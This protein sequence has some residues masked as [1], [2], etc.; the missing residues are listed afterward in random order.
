MTALKLTGVCKS[1]GPVEVLKDID[2]T[3]EEGEF[4]VFVGPSGCGKSTLLR[5][6]AGLEEITSGDVY[7]GGD[8]VKDRIGSIRLTQLGMLLV[9]GSVAAFLVVDDMHAAEFGR[10]VIR[11]LGKTGLPYFSAWT[12]TNDKYG[13]YSLLAH[14]DARK[15][16]G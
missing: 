11:H 12:Y 13:R 5:M 7:I 4:V 6:I 1:F 3:V 9:A 8:R 15:G 14:C 10:H 2:L 16:R